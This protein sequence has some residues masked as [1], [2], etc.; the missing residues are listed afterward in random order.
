MNNEKTK[1]ARRKKRKKKKKKKTKGREKDKRKT[2]KRTGERNEKK[3]KQN[4]KPYHL[5]V[6]AFFFSSPTRTSSILPIIVNET[7][8]RMM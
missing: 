4:T 3:K 2:R 8:T 7:E 1:M 5:P 6:L